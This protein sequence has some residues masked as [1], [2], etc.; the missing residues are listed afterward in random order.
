MKK[1]G[2]YEILEELG[3]GGMGVVYKAY[4][5]LMERQVAVK[6]ILEMALE[7]PEVKSRFYREARTA[8]KLSHENITIVHDVSEDEGR[9][10]IVMEYLT[11]SDLRS[12]LDRHEPM[13]LA[14]KLD[15]ATQICRGLAY[16]H[17]MD[18][19]HRDI[20]PANIRI[21]GNGKVKVMDFG[22]ARLGS[23]NLTST[24]AVIGTPFYMSPEQ[25]QGRKIDKRSDIFSFGVLFYELLTDKKPF[26]ADEPTAVMYKI[27]NETPEAIEETK[28]DHHPGLQEIVSKTL[29]KDPGRRY[30]DL[31]EVA[32]HLQTLL[33]KLK[34]EEKKGAEEQRKKI[35]R[36]LSESKNLL[37]KNRF[38]KAIDAAEEAIRIDKTNSEAAKL[39]N[40]IKQSEERERKRVLVEE[41]LQSARK[42]V[43]AKQYAQAL[44]VL[45]E[46]G[47]IEPQHPEAA[48][49]ARV[50][51]AG[52]TEFATKI[53]PHLAE[54]KA[55][56]GDLSETRA[57]STRVA[58]ERFVAPEIG[59]ISGESFLTTL[60]KKKIY[61][62]AASVILIVGV[63]IV[64]RFFIYAPTPPMG[65]VSLNVLPW[66]EVARIVNNAGGEVPLKEKHVTPC[67]LVLKEGTYNIHFINP[68]FA[69]PL[70][71]TIN[72]K[73]E[74]IQ[75]V[76]KEMPGYD[77]R[78]GIPKF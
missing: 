49:L 45:E 14:Q 67:R 37:K 47:K 10:Y 27:V 55:I 30:Q 23:S 74:E 77:Y 12:L 52:I 35:E 48:Q 11:G 7:M 58:E 57:V 34:S 65:Y 31:N 75:E 41:K 29:E 60:L 61:L 19:I 24:G 72:V 32:D 16:S 64:Y 36:L 26:S 78:Q 59:R 8:G 73:N 66:A 22:I 13:T 54:T 70:I 71:I 56:G 38:K 4:D 46:V 20:K 9:P 2:K 25:I 3:R 69:K 62:I 40:E 53:D 18:I 76:K 6:V 21:L 42:L 43:N 50:A 44:G 28:I 39:L 51:K 63:G 15:Y 5:S 68:A 33:I 1:I 17:S